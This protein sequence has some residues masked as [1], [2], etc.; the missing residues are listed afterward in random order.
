MEIR[1]DLCWESCFIRGFSAAFEIKE[2]RAQDCERIIVA[3]ADFLY[4]DSLSI[5]REILKNPV[6]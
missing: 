3:T 6:Q 1:R 4:E 2:R 5:P